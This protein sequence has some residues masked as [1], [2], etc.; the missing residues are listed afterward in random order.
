MNL[1]RMHDPILEI[2][3][4][5]FTDIVAYSALPADRQRVAVRSLQE[6][7]SSTTDYARPRHNEQLIVL[8]TGDGAA[9]VFFRDAEAPARCAL[10]LAQRLRQEGAFQVRMGIH[11][12]PV[13]RIADIN[14]NRNVTGGGINLA[15]R[16]MELGDAGH[17]LVSK[18][19]A[20]ILVEAS[21]WREWLHDLGQTEIK[22]GASVHIFNL[23]TETAGNPQVPS[24]LSSAPAVIPKQHSA[25]ATSVGL[26]PARSEHGSHI[27]VLSVDDQFH[28]Q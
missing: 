3:H 20:D 18:T 19:V 27:R 13:Y 14:A 21:T 10:E 12:G 1:V 23:Y 8:P 7:I 17:I 9:L 25:K 5:L 16:V 6:A 15:Q 22:H 24:R 2:A 26:E 28:T 11:T 4:V